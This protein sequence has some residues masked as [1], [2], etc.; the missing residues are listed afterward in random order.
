MVRHVGGV[1]GNA[2]NPA[3][4]R[5]AANPA[6]ALNF[7][8]I[9]QGR[10]GPSSPVRLSAHA[11]QR[12]RQRS[13]SLTSADMNRLNQAADKLA[14][15]GGREALVVM[16]QVGLILDVANRTVVTAVE[17]QNLQ[18]NVFTNIDCAVFA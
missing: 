13:I 18:E 9:L 7:R 8:K 1:A 16:D 14:S 2:V 17:R 11:A 4:K 10:L 15:K 12:M 6:Q 5:G 3:A